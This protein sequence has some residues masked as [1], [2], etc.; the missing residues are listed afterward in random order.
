MEHR[1]IH[2][3]CDQVCKNY[4][5][6]LKYLKNEILPYYGFVGDGTPSAPAGKRP[7]LND[8]LFQF[9]YVSLLSI[10]S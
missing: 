2:V 9:S 3:A 10:F 8:A 6:F 7:G 4:C 1:S 5:S